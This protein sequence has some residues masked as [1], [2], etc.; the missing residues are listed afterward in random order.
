MTVHAITLMYL[1]LKLPMYNSL[2]TSR[3]EDRMCSRYV[4]P[5]FV[6]NISIIISFT[7]NIAYYYN[8]LQFGITLRVVPMN[9]WNVQ[10][11]ITHIWNTYGPHGRLFLRGLY[12]PF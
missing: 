7:I 11:W 12:C 3:R 4:R 5:K 8:S 1:K 6:P 9:I 2:K 10:S